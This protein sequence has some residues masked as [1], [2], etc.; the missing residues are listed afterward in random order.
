M[1]NAALKQA[2]AEVALAK[3][4]QRLMETGGV[5]WFF[6]EHPEHNWDEFLAME[7]WEAWSTDHLT[8]EEKALY[9]D[10]YAI[11]NSSIKEIKAM[12]GIESNRIP[13]QWH[14]SGY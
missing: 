2:K 5:C 12:A 10:T 1:A 4:I 14:E 6:E 9:D 13:S 8:A 7:A 3:K 11:E